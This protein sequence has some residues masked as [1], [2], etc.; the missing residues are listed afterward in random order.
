MW[1][2]YTG[3]ILVSVATLASALI[4]VSFNQLTITVFISF[5]LNIIANG[6]YYNIKY[7]PV[8]KVNK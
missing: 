5:Y 6:V 7:I 1:Q 8:M 3:V 4:P 2:R